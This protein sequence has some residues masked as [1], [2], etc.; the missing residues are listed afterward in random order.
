[1]ELAGKKS[2]RIVRS[3]SVG[4]LITGSDRIDALTEKR[5]DKCCIYH[6]RKIQTR[7]RGEKNDAISIRRRV[8]YCRRKEE[9][10]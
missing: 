10:D 6:G 4:S 9:R 7:K 1:M 8:A 3:D 5:F 2:P